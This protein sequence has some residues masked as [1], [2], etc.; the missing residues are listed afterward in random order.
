[1]TDKDRVLEIVQDQPD[2]SSFDEI[3]RELKFAW[4]IELSLM[5]SEEGRTISGEVMSQRIA[6]WAQPRR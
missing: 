5:D 2:D 6:S 3:L 4:M 1:M